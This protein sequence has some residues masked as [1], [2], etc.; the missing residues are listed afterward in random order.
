MKIISFRDGLGNQLFQYQL[1]LYFLRKNPNEKVFGLYKKK[2]LK[3]HNGLELFNYFDVSKPSSTFISRLTAFLLMLFDKCIP[4]IS[5][6]N[7]FKPKAI[8]QIGYWQNKDYWGKIPQKIEFKCLEL[9]EK[10]KIW[11]DLLWRNNSFFIHVRR[12]DYLNPGNEIYNVCD[13]V[14]YNK[15][16]ELIKKKF[17]NPYFFVFSDDIEWTKQNIIANNIFYVDN[18]LGKYSYLDMYLMSQCKGGI[19]ANSTFSY[20]AAILG[21]EKSIIIYPNNWK[22]KATGESPNIFLDNWI[23]I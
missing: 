9:D 1:V 13:T 23:K 3:A 14:Y 6:D 2:W 7:R 11:Y 15:G 12:G 17:D 5:R 4:V 16:I 18:N 19:I 22:I 10:N 20:W 8:L 21:R